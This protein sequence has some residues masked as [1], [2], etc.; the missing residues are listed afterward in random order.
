ML[1]LASDISQISRVGVTTAKRL[2]NIGI[3]TAHDLLYYF[4]YR[5]ED[6]RAVTPIADLAPDTSVNVVGR[7][8]LIG[9]RRSFRRRMY[10]TEAIVADE[11]ERLKVVWFNQPFIAKNL[12]VGDRV[13]LSGKVEGDE[14]GHVMK[15]PAYEKIISGQTVHTQGLVPNYHLTANITQKQIRFL[16]TQVLPLARAIPDWLPPEIM[17]SQK[18]PSLDRAIKHVHFPENFDD[19]EAARKRLAFNE[20]FLL[21]LQSQIAKRELAASRATAI[22]FSEEETQKFVN[23]LPFKLTDAQKKAAWEIIQDLGKDSPMAR[24]LEGDVGSGKTVVAVLAMLNVALNKKQS[25]LMVPTEILAQQHFQSITKLLSGFDIKIGL[26]TA[27]R[28]ELNYQPKTNDKKSHNSLFIIHNSQIVIGTHALIQEKIEFDNLALAIIDEQH[29][30]GVEQRKSL[31]EKSA[32]ANRKSKIENRK[33]QVPHLLSM[34]ATPIPRSLALALY[35]DLDL[36]MIRQM[37]AGRKKILTKVV[38]EEKR[39]DAY[40][41]IKKQIGEGRQIFVICPLID[42][43]DRLGVKSVRQEFEKLDKTIF[44]EIPIGLLHGRMKAKEKEKVMRDFLEQKTK[45]MVSTS[46]I[47]VGVDVPNATIMMIEGADRFG[48]AQ[49]H[50]FRGRV[51]RGEHQSYCFLFTDNEAEKTMRRLKVMEIH[52]DGFLLA[53]MDLKFRGPGEVYGTAQKGF[54]RLRAASLFDYDLMKRARD[55][56]AKLIERDPQLDKFP[57]IKKRLSV[58]DQTVH[59]E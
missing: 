24:L 2:K 18:L 6:F 37:P 4:P 7:I 48:L 39:P 3:G 53:K 29:R 13:S 36:S 12:R 8:E 28:K 59:L 47:E 43:S 50:Q 10:V 51:G 16:I 49:L 30:F 21:Q 54:P 42:I 38:P 5:Y 15:S 9:N 45:I 52:H 57:E 56:A 34:T 41:F 55:E 40:N 1:T 22:N 31:I 46:V 58:F 20:L 23:G 33:S 32:N 17:K 11:T 44:P 14:Y 19:A 25:V 26:V 27:S 35:G